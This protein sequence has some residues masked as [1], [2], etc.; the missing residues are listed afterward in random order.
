MQNEKKTKTL[1]NSLY[2]KTNFKCG[3]SIKV[4]DC[5]FTKKQQKF[6]KP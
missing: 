5:Y 4:G 3:N 1:Y 2:V 6:L